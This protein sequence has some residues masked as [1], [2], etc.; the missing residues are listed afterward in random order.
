MTDHNIPEFVCHAMN[1]YGDTQTSE[2]I[3]DDGTVLIFECATHPVVTPDELHHYENGYI[4]QCL[5][6]IPDDALTNAGKL[7]RQIAIARR[8]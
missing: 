1:E 7:I 4:L 2:L 8:S 6:R 3:Q 5:L